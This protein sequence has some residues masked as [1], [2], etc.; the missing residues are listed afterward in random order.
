[1]SKIRHG[2]THARTHARTFS[3]IGGIH[4]V[5]FCYANQISATGMWIASRHGKERRFSKHM[6]NNMRVLVMFLC[7]S[8]TNNGSDDQSDTFRCCVSDCK[9]PE[10]V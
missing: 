1:M 7:F 9:Y 2:N 8:P 5:L 10:F 6:S 4:I 3:S